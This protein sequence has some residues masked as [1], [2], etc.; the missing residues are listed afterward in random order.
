MMTVDGPGHDPPTVEVR[1]FAALRDA[2]GGHGQ[3]TVQAATV[4]A[5]IG[6]LT[7]RYGET[8][9]R[10]LAVA[11]VLVD[12]RA[13][14]HDDTDTDLAQADEIVALPPFAGGCGGHGWLR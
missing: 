7:D 4:A 12:G 9:R 11:T 10:R 3:V 14:P 1:L 6:A 5:M 13:C 2:A 8:M